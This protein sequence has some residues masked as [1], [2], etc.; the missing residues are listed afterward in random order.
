MRKYDKDELIEKLLGEHGRNV[1]A[2]FWILCVAGY[3]FICS[4]I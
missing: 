1:V 4:R 2:L 3:F